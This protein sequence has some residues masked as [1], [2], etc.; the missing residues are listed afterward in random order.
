M[1]HAVC[2]S[3]AF[4]TLT[5]LVACDKGSSTTAR[6]SPSA[7]PSAATTA[8]NAPPASA[9]P[10]A[11]SPAASAA[12]AAGK[13]AHCPNIVPGANTVIKDAEGGVSLTITAKE[14]ASVTEIRTRGKVLAESAKNMTPDVK[15][16]GSGEGGGSF[17][18]CPVVMRNT[19]VELKDVEGGAELVVKPKDPK[20]LDWL[21]REAR[22]RLAELGDR[23]AKEAGQG[24]MAHC[25]SATDGA[26]TTA[27][28]LKDA[29][30]VTIVG[31]NEAQAKEIRERGKQVIAAAKLEAKKVTHKGDGSGG[32][33]FGRCPVV[34]KDTVV[35]SKEIPLGMAFTVKPEKP[36]ELAQLKKETLERIEKFSPAPVPADKA[37]ADKSDKGKGGR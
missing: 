6:P 30:E 8:A 13:M 16:T 2:V 17:G 21:K 33:G 29:V 10:S 36:G 31:T 34:L 1:R 37:K 18:R 11:A 15:H 4:A 12:L 14:P 3:W 23:A 9:S 24:K 22:E 32:G 20:E 5:A 27:K 26:K 28:D 19:A 7:A 25:P 35:E